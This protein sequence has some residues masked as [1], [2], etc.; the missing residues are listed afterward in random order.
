MKIPITA[1]VVV[2]VPLMLVAAVGFVVYKKKK[3]ES[4]KGGELMFLK[5][6]EN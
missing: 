4:S 5:R 3:C 6:L 2:L 1:V